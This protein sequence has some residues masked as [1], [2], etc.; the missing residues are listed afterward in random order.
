MKISHAMQQYLKHLKTLGRSAYTIKS[1]RYGLKSLAAFLEDEKVGSIEDLDRDI[2]EAYQEELS[3]RLTAK[4]SPLSLCAREKLIN[5]TQ[6]FT[7]FL[8]HKEY[9]LS[10]PG[11]SLQP[12]KRGR[13]LP[14]SILSHAE[15]RQLL[16]VP[17]HRTH[18]GQRNRLV[19]EILYDTGI[20][21]SEVAAIR[22]TDLD[23]DTGY[24]RINGKGDKDRVVPV[25][26]RVGQLIKNYILFVRP[27]FV[28]S[29]DSGHLI[30]NRSGNP[31]AANGI[32][33]IVKTC[34]RLA[35]IKKKVTTHGLRHT[36]ATHMLK[37]GAPVRHIQ[38]MLGHESL[39]STQIYTH[40]TINDLKEVHARFHP[41]Q[42]LSK[43]GS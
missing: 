2:L 18:Q 25:S 8:K 35:G 22:L 29:S 40:V 32:Y 5:V 19:L 37:N 11:E 17:N 1:A 6:G 26:Q 3:Y 28:K 12:P 27:A 16:D 36:C 15:I 38:E 9:L 39:E 30:L 20:R 41:S 7:R 10:D 42:T 31:M 14:R 24:V 43:G 21:R 4:G 23:L 34:A 33:I 13:R